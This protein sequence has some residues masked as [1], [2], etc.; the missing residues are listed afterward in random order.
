MIR[1]GANIVMLLRRFPALLLAAIL[2]ACAQPVPFT[3]PPPS[4]TVMLPTVTPEATWTPQPS[5]TPRPTATAY[6][7]QQPY[8]PRPTLTP[9]PS[10]TPYPSPTPQTTPLRLPRAR[11]L[12]VGSAS[13]AEG[14]CWPRYMYSVSQGNV[15]TI[16]EDAAGY[17][18]CVATMGAGQRKV[19]K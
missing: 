12:P 3:P 18:F 16:T 7:T 4:A 1:R 11:V 15:T 6:P 2:A 8:T 14:V 10:A 5:Y 19:L 9:L 17:R 13:Y